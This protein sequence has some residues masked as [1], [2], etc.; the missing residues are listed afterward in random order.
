MDIIMMLT[1][2][3]LVV[4]LFKVFKVPVTKWTV[5]TAAF[6]GGLLMGWIYISMAYFH[7]Y[8][9]YG[10]EYF[11]TTPISINVK[12]KVTEVYV[13]DT[14]ALKK[15]DKIF[16]IDPKPFESV[17]KTLDAE[18]TLAQ[19]RLREQERLYKKKAG[20][21]FD[22]EDRASKVKALQAQLLKANFD[23]NNTL[24]TAPS[25]GHLV[26]NRIS[27]GTM[28]GS[29]KVSSLLTFV[30][31]KKSYFV[32]G[33]RTNGISNIKVGADAEVY[34]VAKPG[35]VFK[36]RVTKVWKEIA[37]GQLLPFSKMKSV[38]HHLEHGRI[39]VEFEILEDISAYEIPKGS[40]FGATVYSTHLAFLGEL[41]SI[42]F[43]MFSWQNIINFE[44]I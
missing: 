43:H 17:V 1:Y 7:P 44:E 24:V 34:F 3:A 2:V 37:E 30:P 23:L 12:G 35:K 29:F 10:K 4:I 5:T 36:A 41:R 25:D 22:L 26:Q 6:G 39:P 32:A 16:K 11:E 21:L 19:E 14:R 40:A 38:S 33:F 13:K 8:S 9:P 42:F 20:T 28:A 15:G 27:V 18:L 31:D